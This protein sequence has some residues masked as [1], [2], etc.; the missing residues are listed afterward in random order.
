MFYLVNGKDWHKDRDF[1]H[2]FAYYLKLFYN[3][4]ELP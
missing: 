4:T 2:T 1:I 3:Q